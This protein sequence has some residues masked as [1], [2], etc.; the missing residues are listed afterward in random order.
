[1]WEMT[2]SPG[3]ARRTS[4]S[5]VSAGK[6]APPSPLMEKPA[7]LSP[8]RAAMARATSSQCAVPGRK[9]RGARPVRSVRAAWLPMIS[10]HT[11]PASAVPG[12]P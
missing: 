12:M 4:A 11:S 3:P 6:V 7:A 10:S 2:T 5:T 9:K 8:S 1:M